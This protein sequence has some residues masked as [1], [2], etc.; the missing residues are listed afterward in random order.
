M[1]KI[2]AAGA[3]LLILSYLLFS[4]NEVKY[5][6]GIVA[7]KIPLQ[8]TDSLPGNFQ[9]ENYTLQ[10]LATFEIEARV[11]SKENYS[12][13]READLAET[14][15]T[16]GWGPMSDSKVLAE[17]DI[18]QGGRFYHWQVSDFP[19]PRRDIEIHSANMHLIPADAAV[20]HMIDKV[21][22]GQVVKLKGLL[23]KVMAEDNWKWVSSL[24][25]NDTGGGACEL[26]WVKDFDFFT[27]V[28]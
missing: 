3:G 5:G 13:G 4:S 28:P 8:T 12:I 11:L 20:S 14:D 21:K 22:V 2:L 6:P 27:P 18:S 16:F 26:I 7:P 1:K 25:R 23:V 15:I 17:I 9:F 10:P 24:T 19:I